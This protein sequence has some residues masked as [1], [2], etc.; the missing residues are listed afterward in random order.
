MTGDVS[1]TGFQLWL[2][3]RDE[4][5]CTLYED[6]SMTELHPSEQ[7]RTRPLGFYTLDMTPVADPAA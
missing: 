5:R 1:F 6:G 2:D 3:A 4:L 7:D